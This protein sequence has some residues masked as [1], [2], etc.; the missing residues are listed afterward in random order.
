MQNLYSED[1]TRVKLIDT[2]FMLALGVKKISR[3]IIISPMD[4]NS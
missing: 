4:A 3:E 1:D 2:S